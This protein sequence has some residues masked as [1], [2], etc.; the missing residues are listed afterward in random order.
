MFKEKALSADERN[1]WVKCLT[2]EEQCDFDHLRGE[3]GY[4]KAPGSTYLGAI[5]V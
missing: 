3:M 4:G 2:L 1:Y 5:R